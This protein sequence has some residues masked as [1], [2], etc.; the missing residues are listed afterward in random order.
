[1]KTTELTLTEKELNLLMDALYTRWP[2]GT[3]D[4]KPES[5]ASKL[6]ER[7]YDS[8]DKFKKSIEDLGECYHCDEP[9]TTK[10]SSYC[11]IRCEE[12]ETNVE[13]QLNAEC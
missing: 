8:K 7:L 2:L 12:A 3:L 13:W 4:E 9:I 10:N 11:S 5:L 1:M 6:M